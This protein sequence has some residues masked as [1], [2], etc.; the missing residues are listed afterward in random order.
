MSDEPDTERDRAML[1]PADRRFLSDPDE[2]AEGRTRKSVY[3]RRQAIAGRLTG[4]LRDFQGLSRRL[5]GR[6]WDDVTDALSNNDSDARRG[7]ISAISLFYELHESLGWDFERTLHEAINEAYT[8][9]VM[10]REL[11]NRTVDDVSFETELIEPDDYGELLERVETK[12]ETGK[13]LTDAEKA[14]LLERDGRLR[15]QFEERR[16]ESEV[17]RIDRAKRK[18]GAESDDEPE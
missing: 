6:V 14:W 13:P 11:E 3:N 8:Y 12:L 9:G 16:R 5:T 2:Y 10:N 15:E 18:Y 4:T 1:A 17:R 7:M